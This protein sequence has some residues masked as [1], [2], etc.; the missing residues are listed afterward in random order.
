[1]AFAAVLDEQ[2]MALPKIGRKLL[3]NEMC[4][5]NDFLLSI[6]GVDPLLVWK[7]VQSHPYFKRP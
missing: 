6:Q 2:E 3:K 1:M 7:I 5:Q 4:R